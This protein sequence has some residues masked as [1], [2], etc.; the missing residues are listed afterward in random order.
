MC[1]LSTPVLSTKPLTLA[2]LGFGLS[3]SALSAADIQLRIVG[4]DGYAN[5]EWNRKF[6]EAYE[7]EHGK[8]VK[9]TF[10]AVASEMDFFTAARQGSADLITPGIELLKDDK[11]AFSKGLILPLDPKAIPNL[12]KVKPI[13]NRVPEALKGD[14]LLFAPFVAGSYLLYY[15][16]KRTTQP[17]TGYGD[18]LKPAFAKHYSLGDYPVHNAVMAALASGV[19]IQDASTYDKVIGFPGFQANFKQLYSQAANFWNAVDN[20]AAIAPPEVQVMVGFG[21]AVGDAAKA[22][23][24]LTPVIPSEGLLSFVDHIGITSAAAANPEVKAAAEAFINFGLSEEYQR[25]V[26]LKT[27][28]CQPVRQGVVDNLDEATKQQFQHLILAANYQ[29]KQI[30]I[31]TVDKRS[32]NGFETLHKQASAK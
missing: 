25:E 9:V 32:R 19:P 4:Y 17:P 22:G 30:F 5:P 13:Y 7:A 28:C 18:L 12:A 8:K 29:G 24:P 26:V 3:F 15:D 2:L 16:A 31:P 21:F 11:F 23:Q 20:A 1:V 6:S 10:T 27:L 14:Q